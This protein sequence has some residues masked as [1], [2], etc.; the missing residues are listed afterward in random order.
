VGPSTAWSPL[1]R[2][3]DVVNTIVAELTEA[4]AT[5]HVKRA[6]ATLG[7]TSEHNLRGNVRREMKA[8]TQIAQALRKTVPGIGTLKMPDR[9]LAAEGLLKAAA[10]LGK[11]ASTY[12]PVLIEHG[13]AQDTLAQLGTAVTTLQSSVDARGSA[14]AAQVSATKTVKVNLDLARQYV[15]LMDAAISRKTE[16]DAA[17]LAEWKNAKRVTVKGV[18]A[19][20]PSPVITLST[21]ATQLQ[22]AA[23]ST[24]TSAV[25]AA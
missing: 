9:Q 3:L 14:R 22:S 10:G 12:E 23:G 17:K 15:Q 7:A 16:T 21:P 4:A 20:A 6:Q 19:G 5:Q 8:V 24:S 18:P 2:Q 1:T 11:M 25:Q 13:L